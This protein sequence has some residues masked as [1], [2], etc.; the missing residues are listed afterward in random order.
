MTVSVLSTREESDRKSPARRRRCGPRWSRLRERVWWSH[1]RGF[2]WQRLY[3]SATEHDSDSV[4]EPIRGHHLERF[5]VWRLGGSDDRPVPWRLRS[6]RVH[7]VVR[8]HERHGGHVPRR[9]LRE[10]AYV[11][12]PSSRRVGFAPRGSPSRQRVAGNRVD[13][14]VSEASAR[15]SRARCTAALETR[16]HG[17]SAGR[18]ASCARDGHVGDAVRRRASRVEANAQAACA[19]AARGCD[20]ERGR[21]LRSRDVRSRAGA[22]SITTDA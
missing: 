20:R 12:A 14:C 3:D 7:C 22:L 2:R 18:T 1:R 4:W 8:S 17:G 19:F 21:R 10:G 15:A 5:G 11:D 9:L 6:R 13:W 16:S